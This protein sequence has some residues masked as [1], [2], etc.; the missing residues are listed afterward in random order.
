MTKILLPLPPS[1]RICNTATN[2]STVALVRT[3]IFVIRVI[4][5]ILFLRYVPAS[6]K[7]YSDFTVVTENI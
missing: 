6:L 5:M 3:V 2:I 7:T 1:C 4:M